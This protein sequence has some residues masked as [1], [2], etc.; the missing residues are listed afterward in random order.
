MGEYISKSRS[1]SHSRGSVRDLE[2]GAQSLHGMPSQ[3]P[4]MGLEEPKKSSWGCIIAIVVILILS[5]AALIGAALWWDWLDLGLWSNKLTV[6][7]NDDTYISD[8]LN[9]TH[10]DNQDNQQGTN[11]Q[12]PA[13]ATPW[14]K[15]N[16]KTTIFLGVL[17]IA[18][19][20]LGYDY[21]NADS[22][23]STLS[24]LKESVTSIWSSWFKSD[25]EATAEDALNVSA[26]CEKDDENCRRTA[27]D[28]TLCKSDAVGKDGEAACV[29]ALV[30]KSD[31][32]SFASTRP[33]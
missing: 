13:K 23:A 33:R 1:R 14:W 25:E 19:L 16:V 28:M 24:G 21:Y 6:K 15:R 17:G 32:G 7:D 26:L 18:S 2:Y 10:D 3:M 30:W 4:M 27:K 20:Y 12:T 29:S 9:Y 8:S 31:V 11:G 5:L 22:G